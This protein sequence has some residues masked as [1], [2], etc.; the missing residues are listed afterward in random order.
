M[1]EYAQPPG[2]AQDAFHVVEPLQ[3][4][5][6]WLQILGWM[7]IASGVLECLTIIG[8]VIGWLP[9]WIGVLV[10]RTAK[11][12]D[13]GFRDQNAATL[14]EGTEALGKVIMLQGIL[15]LIGVALTALYIAV[16]I[17]AILLPWSST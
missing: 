16:F 7:A 12:L 10:L 17:V 8:A 13:E 14:R 1:D 9:I 3:K 5:R 15:A 6:L 4:V 2:T 11:R